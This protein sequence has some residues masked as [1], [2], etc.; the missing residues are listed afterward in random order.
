MR[1]GAPAL[2]PKS[3]LLMDRVWIQLILASFLCLPGTQRREK[4]VCSKAGAQLA[5]G[6]REQGTG[7]TTPIVRYLGR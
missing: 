6:N 1:S 4:Q 3:R 5:L 7:R 2:R